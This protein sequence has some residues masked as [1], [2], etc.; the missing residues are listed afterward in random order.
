MAMAGLVDTKENVPQNWTPHAKIS[1]GSDDWIKVV[2]SAS[3]TCGIKNDTNRELWCWGD[4]TYGQLA[5]NPATSKNPNPTP[6][7]AGQKWLDVTVG[8]GHTC[9]IKIDGSNIHTLWCWGLNDKAQLG[10]EPLAPDLENPP[11]GF[12]NENDVDVPTQITVTPPNALV[13]TPSNDGW[14]SIKAGNKY[15]CGLNNTIKSEELLFCW[16]DDSLGQVGTGGE[17]ITNIPKVVLDENTI[18]LD[19]ETGQNSACAVINNKRLFCWGDNNNSQLTSNVASDDE[20]TSHTPES[21]AFFDDWQ[22][23][24]MGKNHGCGIREDDLGNRTAYCWGEGA[25]YQLGD[26]NAWK[27]TPLRLSL[28]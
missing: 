28:E 21:A 22:T 5:Q 19:Y 10:N 23:L 20:G 6:V 26:G 24:A 7:L 4:N 25:E 16:G 2:T 15:T 9:A 17:L 1:V 27:E 14:L 13:I 18:W 8:N 12:P 11:P 3:H